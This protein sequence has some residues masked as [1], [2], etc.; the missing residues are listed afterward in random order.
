MIEPKENLVTE[1]FKEID[2]ENF[3]E[4][5]D[6]LLE[7]AKAI[8][9]SAN[10]G[11]EKNNDSL[12]ISDRLAHIAKI[13]HAYHFDKWL[14]E[15]KKH[16][17][18][19]ANL[20]KRVGKNYESL[21]KEIHWFLYFY[22]IIEEITENKP[23]KYERH[24]RPYLKIMGKISNNDHENFDY[25]T[26]E[27]SEHIDACNRYI[28]HL[29]FGFENFFQARRIKK[30]YLFK[31]Y[32]IVD[33]VKSKLKKRYK[34]IVALQKSILSDL[35]SLNSIPSYAYFEIPD[36]CKLREELAELLEEQSAI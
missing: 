12:E 35:E 33:P 11:Q 31:Y 15:K 6:L 32:K 21:A 18:K 20:E 22:E 2:N 26:K 4:V 14:I 13:F 36:E 19:I 30:G 23:G 1:I 3:K 28:I 17:K 5:H 10:F 24:I 34:N 8:T 27:A 16:K 29:D 25:F 9:L 7:A